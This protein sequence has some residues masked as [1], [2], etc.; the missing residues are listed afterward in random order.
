MY[1]I[2]SASGTEAVYN[3]LEDFTAAVRRGEVVPEDEIF[4]SRAN[5]WLDIKS[6]PH[7]RSAINWSGP[8]SAEAIFAPPPPAASPP[9]KPAPQAP[10]TSVHNAPHPKPQVSEIPAPNRPATVARPQ[11]A[12]DAPPKPQSSPTLHPPQ[13]RPPAKTSELTFVQVDPPAPRPPQTPPQRQ[14]VTVVQVPKPPVAATPP[15]APPPAAAKPKGPDFLVMDTGLEHPVRTSNGHRMITG[16]ADM[17]FDV[18]V[19]EPLPPSQAVTVGAPTPPASPPTRA[20]PPAAPPRHVESVTPAHRAPTPAADPVSPRVSATV[21]APAASLDIPGPALLESEPLP[22]IHV[23]RPRRAPRTGLAIGT[24]LAVTI[25]GGALIAFH[26][27]RGPAPTTTDFRKEVAPT[28]VQ[29]LPPFVGNA[30]TTATV[31]AAIKPGAPVRSPAVP[32]VTQADSARPAPSDEVIAARPRLQ[33]DLPA[34]VTDLNLA[35]DLGTGTTTATATVMS[36][37]DL[38]KHLDAAERQARQDLAARLG[39]FKAVLNAQRLS[40]SDGVA[41][42]RSAWTAGAEAIRQ[43]RAR[44]ARLERAYEDSVLAS[45]RTSHWSP[46]DMRPWASHESL[47]EPGETSQMADLM[48]SQV[49][50]GLGI[51]ASLDG[52]YDIQGGKIKFQNPTDASRYVSIRAWVEQRTQAWSATPEGARPYTIGLILRAL[53]DGFPPVE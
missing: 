53:G 6:H 39:V 1:R 15:A 23:S 48:L 7:Y 28:Q 22:A 51:L 46:D 32:G 31:A 10:A 27:W 26:P 37:A 13:P 29:G 33:P 3:S 38:A 5:R 19:A 42:A 49:S 24:G 34:P 45:Q 11:L 17:L 52:S 47:A 30:E 40:G 14:N 16:D 44:I 2:R 12:A 41:Q 50:E 8:L 43:Y 21:V 18:P 9:P 25:A 4:H 20:T 36:P 35:S